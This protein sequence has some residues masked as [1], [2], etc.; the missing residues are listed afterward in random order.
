MKRTFFAAIA[1]ILMVGLLASTPLATKATPT[2]KVYS[3]NS[4]GQAYSSKAATTFT[5]G[6]GFNFSTA[7]NTALLTT[8]DKSLTGDLTG[9]T[10][11]ANFTITGSSDAAFTYYGDPDGCGTPATARLYFTG[12]GEK[13]PGFYSNYWWSNPGSQAISVSGTAM[14]ISVPLTSSWSNWNGKPVSDVP[15]NFA[16]AVRSVSSVGVS[17]GGGCFFANGVGITAGSAQF[18]LTSFT[19]TP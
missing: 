9:K 17:F 15:T 16:A 13:S 1:A 19:V 10:L 8:Q 2:W 5:T 14:S 12:T 11:T 4:S 18:I 3:F 6:S 7:P